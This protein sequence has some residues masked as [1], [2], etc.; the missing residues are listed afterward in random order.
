MPIWDKK[1]TKQSSK[2]AK[3][4]PKIS[5]THEKLPNKQKIH[6]YPETLKPLPKTAL[7]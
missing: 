5:K 2:I 1:K 6:E 3:I 7:N 4:R